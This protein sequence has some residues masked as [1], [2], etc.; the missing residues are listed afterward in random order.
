MTETESASS[1]SLYKRLQ[2]FGKGQF[3][4]I[5]QEQFKSNSANLTASISFL[6]GAIR[7]MAE[8]EDLEDYDTVQVLQRY[9]MAKFN[10]PRPNARGVIESNQRLAKKYVFLEDAFREGREAATAWCQDENTPLLH[11]NDFLRQHDDITM[12]DLGKKGVIS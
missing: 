9:I 10:M 2:A 12:S 3:E 4:Y 1:E 5:D 7:A 6:T 8:H 11:L